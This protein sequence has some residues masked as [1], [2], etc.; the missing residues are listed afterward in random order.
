[1]FTVIAPPTVNAGNG[2]SICENA[3]SIQLSGFSPAGGTWSGPGVSVSGLFNPLSAGSGSKQLVYTFTA[4]TGC[5][6]IDT[7]LM[8]VYPQASPNFN[9]SAKVC[10]LDTLTLNATFNSLASINT[11]QWLVSN[12][13]GLSNSILN[14]YNSSTA[15][16]IFPEN[17]TSND[18]SYTFKLKLTTNFGCVDSV[19]KSITQLRRP[20]AN[21]VTGANINCGPANYTKSNGTNNVASTYLWSVN[22]T[23]GVSV[24]TSS[25]ANPQI[26]LPVNTSNSVI[27]YEVKLI[28]TRNTADL[29]CRD[30]FTAPLLVYPKPLASFTMSPTSSGCSPQTV[31]FTNV[32]NPKNSENIGEPKK[33]KIRPNSPI[34]FDSETLVAENESL[35][36]YVLKSYLKRQIRFR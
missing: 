29:G 12:N 35:E 15:T 26:G 25:S 5:S 3:N 2:F 8:T 33:K 10:A 9:L 22:P 13:G 32:S 20:H 36:A 34:L 28:A 6:G 31:L 14:T 19:S 7:L 30:T 17:Q 11:Y 4:G 24:V 16:A 18:Y 1:L 21:F 23:S 27:N